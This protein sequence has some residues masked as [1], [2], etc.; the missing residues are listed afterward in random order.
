MKLNITLIGKSVGGQSGQPSLQQ[1]DYRYNIR[2]WLTDINDTGQLQKTGQPVDLFAFKINYNEDVPSYFPNNSG[3]KPLYNGNI[4]ETYWR[5]ASDNTLR[6]YGYDYDELN[7]LENA[8][9]QKPNSI[10]P[11]PLTFDEYLIVLPIS[12]TPIRLI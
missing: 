9:Y 11:L 6:G 4:A 1:V 10:T 8:Y 2:G 12:C 5:T 7:R 3:V